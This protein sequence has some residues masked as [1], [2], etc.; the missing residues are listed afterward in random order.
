MTTECMKTVQQQMSRVN[1]CWLR[2]T[3]DYT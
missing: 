1:V 3:Y 2:S